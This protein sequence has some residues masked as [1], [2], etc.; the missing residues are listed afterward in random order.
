MSE[1]GANT[2]KSTDLPLMKAAIRDVAR[3]DSSAALTLLSSI[4]GVSL[5]RGEHVTSAAAAAATTGG[6]WR[7]ACSCSGGSGG[8]VGPPCENTPKGGVEKTLWEGASGL[9]VWCGGG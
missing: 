4:S 5:T 9:V 1:C 8:R 2:A 7:E 3:S 6:Q